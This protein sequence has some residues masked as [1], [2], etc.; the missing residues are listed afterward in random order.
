M[1]NNFGFTQKDAISGGLHLALS[2]LVVLAA[3]TRFY[4]WNLRGDLFFDLHAQFG[5][6]YT[7]LND[8]V[9]DFAERL[10]TLGYV[11]CYGLANHETISGIPMD[12]SDTEDPISMSR[13]YVM[14][15]FSLLA[16]LRNLATTANQATD[17]GTE[18]LAKDLIA[19]LEK[20]NWKFSTFA[21]EIDDESESEDETASESTGEG[22]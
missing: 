10:R 13:E 8:K 2:D 19:S 6:L 12:I 17:Y 5:E 7:F 9:D 18:V 21:T 14:D 11:P 1:L 15:S 20:Y 4:H 16:T 3:K 22:D